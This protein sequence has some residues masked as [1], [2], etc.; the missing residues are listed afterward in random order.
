M[1]KNGCHCHAM[2]PNPH[3][4]WVTDVIS[5]AY[6][7]MEATVPPQWLPKLVGVSSK[8]RGRLLAELPEYGCGV[9]GCVF[10]TLVPEI[11][12]K[13]TSDDTEAEFAAHLA[14]TLAAPI[15]VTYHHV[16]STNATHKG[17]HIYFLWRES[18]QHVGKMFDTID[19]EGGDADR[20]ADALMVQHG[21]AQMA[22][23]ALHRGDNA[24][25][26]IALWLSTLTDIVRDPALPELHEWAA[27]MLTVYREQH[28]LFGDVHEG[29]MGQV[30]RPD[31]KHWVITDPGH[32]AVVQR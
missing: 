19:E 15:C 2:T 12:L 24:D 13:V 17:G 30:T 6:E 1:R 20:A 8:R 4:S 18:A 31:G 27:G 7:T 22:Y 25:D 26:E 3:P 16:I 10:P 5:R 14:P 23:A 21:T 29:N 28:I 11:V 9:Y 32:V